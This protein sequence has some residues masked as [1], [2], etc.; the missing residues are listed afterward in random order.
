[1]RL[2]EAR[3]QQAPDESGRWRLL[4]VAGGVLLLS[5]L[6]VTAARAGVLPEDRADV[7]YHYLLLLFQAGVRFQDV[8]DVLEK[9][10]R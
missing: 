5:L 8:A 3:A 10:R 6:I 9:R 1:M 4:A 2:T 7:L